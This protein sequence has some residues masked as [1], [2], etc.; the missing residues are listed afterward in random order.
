NEVLDLLPSVVEINGWNHKRIKLRTLEFLSI[1]AMDRND[2]A[3]HESLSNQMLPLLEE[4]DDQEGLAHLF[5]DQGHVALFNG[6]ISRADEFL[7]RSLIYRIR[8]NSFNA[9][10]VKYML[11]IVAL[12]KGKLQE[13]QTSFVDII[14]YL[15][16]NYGFW[17]IS[18]VLW[19]LADLA[20]VQ[21]R[22][23]VAGQLLGAADHL[24]QLTP[25]HFPKF[26][27]QAYEA[28]IAAARA[29]LD[30]TAYASAYAEGYAMIPDQAVTF[31]L[32]QFGEVE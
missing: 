16:A 27:H 22:S 7:Q 30:E 24:R 20:I 15:Y 2:V 5:V 12:H 6:E 28:T 26:F 10:W 13:A 3:Q 23:I 21:Q 1:C 17:N 8:K 19:G 32:A 9:N 14:H 4:L 25:D 31:A 11:G 18:Y 29:Q